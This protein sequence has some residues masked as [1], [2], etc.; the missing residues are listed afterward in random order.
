MRDPVGNTTALEFSSQANLLQSVRSQGNRTTRFEHNS[1]GEPVKMT[2]PLNRDT[3]M[4]YDAAGRL[5]LYTNGLGQQTAFGYNARDQLTTVTDANSGVTTFGYDSNIRLESVTDPLNQTIER[6]AYT[7]ASRLE[8]RT[9]AFS[10]NTTYTYNNRGW[11]TEALDR[12]GQRITIDRDAVGRITGITRPDATTSYRYDAIGRLI[13]VSEGSNR[14]TVDYDAVD[15]PIRE[16]HQQA[17]LLVTLDHTWDD[18]DRRMQRRISAIGASG[19]LSAQT[20]DYV[21]DD[22]DRIRSIRQNGLTTTY[23]WDVD[24]RLTDKTLPNGIAVKYTYDDA[25]QVTAIEYRRSDTTLVE[26]IAYQYDAA[27]RRT[28]KDTLV[29]PTVEETPF[30]A[31]YD[32]GN[33]VTSITLN[34]ASAT[35]T[36]YTLTY[37]SHGNLAE[38]RNS[39]N[40]SDVTTYG[41]DSRDRLS[42]LTTPGLT[43]SFSYDSLG[44]RVSRTI[45]QAGQPATTTNYVYDGLQ[46]S[47]EIRPQQGSVAEQGTALITGIYLDEMIARVASGAGGANPQARTYLTDALGSV[48]SQTRADQTALNSYGYSAYGQA[49]AGGDDEG[50]SIE[51]TARENDNTSLLFYRARYYD[52]VLKR[53][54]QSDPIGLRGGINTYSYVGGNPISFADP[55]GQLPI[56][57]PVIT[58]GIGAITSG[59]GYVAGRWARGCDIDLKELAVSIGVGAIREPWHRLLARSEM[60]LSEGR[61]MSSRMR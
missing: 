34:P 23:V 53:F 37:D 26:R 29:S 12:K 5:D 35:P 18:L 44:R 28:L 38:K 43:A 45:T 51:Y 61:E 49:F 22:A 48:I 59:L 32:Q 46:A 60:R 57:V 41:W 30:M 14:L 11:L 9:D 15:R 20:T 7:N 6:Y 50:N 3:L 8:A 42:Q 54:V 47:G 56:A 19:S 17:D 13:E 40:N 31:I 39:V 1:K 33:R 4:R 55:D 24:N 16:T 2:D 58:G 10:R 27:G 36:N 25:S 21:Y 52:P